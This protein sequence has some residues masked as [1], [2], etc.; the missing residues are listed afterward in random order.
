MLFRSAQ[1]T[2]GGQPGEVSGATVA[3][4]LE[5]HGQGGLG[6]PEL[7]EG[8]FL[9]KGATLHAGQRVIT[10]AGLRAELAL[11]DGT[12]VRVDEASELVLPSAEAGAPIHLQTGRVIVVAG[13]NPAAIESHN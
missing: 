8:V 6:S 1:A 11:N 13:Q 4:I 12:R 3:T 2:Q 9:G 10:P 5:L 7:G